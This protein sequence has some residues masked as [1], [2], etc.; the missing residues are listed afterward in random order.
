MKIK[1]IAL[2]DLKSLDSN[3]EHTIHSIKK[4]QN[5][6]S[7]FPVH[8]SISKPKFESS[9]K[10]TKNLNLSKSTLKLSKPILSL[11]SFSSLPPT[12]MSSSLTPHGTIDAISSKL[13]FLLQSDIPSPPKLRYLSNLS[14]PS[15]ACNYYSVSTRS[16]LQYQLPQFLQKFI[17]SPLKLLK[18]IFLPSFIKINKIWFPLIISLLIFTSI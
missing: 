2:K 9:P 15:P 6:F 1:A 5:K 17:M 7:D 11:P 13:Q 3:T 14:A 8:R 12:Q 16:E 4:L 18:F 10:T